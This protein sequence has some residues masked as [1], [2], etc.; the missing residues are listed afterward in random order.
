MIYQVSKADK[1]ISGRIHLSGSKSI[2][3][4]VLIMEAL[5]GKTVQKQNLSDSN[6][7]NLLTSLLSATGNEFDAHDAGTAFRFLTAYLAIKE[8]TWILTGSERMKQRPIGDLV[9]PLRLLGARI[10]YL[11]REGFPPLK[12][13]GSSMTGGHVKVQ[14]GISSQFASALL[15]IAPG[16]RDGLTLELTGE[17]VSEP[18]IDMTLSLMKHFG[19]QHTRSAASIHIAPQSYQPKDIFIESDWSAASYYYEMAAF[20]D[21]LD[22]TLAG[23]LQHS[24]QGDAKIAS[25]MESFGVAT[26][27]SGQEIKLSKITPSAA[28]R[29]HLKDQPDLAPAMFV[30]SGGLSVPARFT[31]LEHLQYKESDREA[32]LRSELLKCGITI[33]RE[34]EAITIDGQ[35]R[36]VSTSFSTYLD[37][38]MAMAFAPLAILC[39]SVNIENPAVVKKSYPKYWDDIK[40]LGFAISE[41]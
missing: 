40:S 18:Y 32:A 26:S 24:F 41:I 7:T 31:G 6:D 12:I 25:F 9:D 23:L 2:S 1:R 37:H 5:M 14:A 34:G 19:V 22:L 38:R 21:E 39:G 16:M 27:Y 28:L 29:F 11:G 10:E 35:F 33:G 17:V 13:T 30:T 3:N 20:S 8:G 36:P 15:M 4:R